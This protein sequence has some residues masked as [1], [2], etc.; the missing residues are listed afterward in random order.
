MQ[1]LYN[2]NQNQYT[3]FYTSKNSPE[4][5]NMSLQ[6]PINSNQNSRTYGS[7]SYQFSGHRSHHKSNEKQIDTDNY[8]L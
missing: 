4:Y 2:S 1:R 7:Q 5:I 3:N 8:S 6:Y